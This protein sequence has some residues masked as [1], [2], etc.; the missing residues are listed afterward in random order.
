MHTDVDAKRLAEGYTDISSR[1]V[2][3]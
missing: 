2:R 3:A 1:H